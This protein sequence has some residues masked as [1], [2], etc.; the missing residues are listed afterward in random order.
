M[1]IFLTGF[2]GCG[3]TTIAKELASLLNFPF[4]DLDQLIEQAEGQSISAIF[5]NHGEDTF[6]EKEAR[7]L[8][9]TGNSNHFVMS[10]GGGAPC[11]HDNIRWMNDRGLSIYLRVPAGVLYSR[12]QQEENL[13]RPLLKGLEGPKLYDF[14]RE[15]LAERER[16]YLQSKFV[17]DWT[18]TNASDILDLLKN[19]DIKV[20]SR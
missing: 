15:K 3:K 14:I 5:S 4:I 12:L 18:I 7:Y 20:Y 10:A 17:V 2:M 16:Y 8:R 11:Y 13:N 19:A 1:K 9:E 6:R